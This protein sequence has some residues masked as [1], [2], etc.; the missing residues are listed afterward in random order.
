MLT[1][2]KAALAGTGT[3]SNT[4]FNS[5]NITPTSQVLNHCL[6]LPSGQKDPKEETVEWGVAS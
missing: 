6:A 3:A 2:K 1:N 5:P 4:A